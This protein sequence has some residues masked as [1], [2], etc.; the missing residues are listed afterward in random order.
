MEF[1]NI[2]LLLVVRDLGYSRIS[3]VEDPHR[4]EKL[5]GAMRKE[6]F[7]YI[8]DAT[9]IRIND[10]IRNFEFLDKFQ[11]FSDRRANEIRLTNLLE[12]RVEGNPD[13][14]FSRLFERLVESHGARRSINRARTRLKKTFHDYR[15]SHLLER[16]KGI[17]L[18]EF[19]VKVSVPFAYKNGYYNLIDSIRLSENHSESLREAGKKAIEGSLIWRSSSLFSQAKLVIVADF[20]EQSNGFYHALA[21]HF[22]ESNVKLYRYDEIGMLVDDIKRH[23]GSHL[24]LSYS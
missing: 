20:S 7:E 3:F 23:G 15:V 11:E 13:I 9:A 8:K 6:Y 2:G 5:F 10:I 18:R 4:V 21:Q 19:D 12:V 16:P 17:E 14:E 22:E 1:I 24:A